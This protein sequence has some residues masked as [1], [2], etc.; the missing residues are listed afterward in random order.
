[1]QLHL[2]RPTNWA[3]GGA[4]T[5][6]TNTHDLTEREIALLLRL[7]RATLIPTSTVGDSMTDDRSSSLKLVTAP[8]SEPI[9]LAQA[10][11]FLRVEH[12]GDDEAITRAISAARV[13][14]EQYCKT[15][16]LP[17]TW[18]YAKAN[19]EPTRLHLPIGPAQ[20]ISS[21]TLTTEAGAS[22]T[23]NAAN[24]RLSVAGFSVLF[25]PAISIERIT[26]RYVAGIA[27][28]VAD[29]PSSLAQGM[30]HHIA[31]MMETRD[32]AAPMPMQSIA[33]YQPYRRISL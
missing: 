32:G 22:S 3:R 14:A 31:V 13:A 33:C 26:V 25:D 24:Y 9:T 29:M 15:A 19:P 6:I 12:T 2:Y 16:F 7:K 28:T 4:S 21:I 30:L 20:S 10:K 11:I 18:D 23:M 1:M 5:H 8:A 27:T 17:Q